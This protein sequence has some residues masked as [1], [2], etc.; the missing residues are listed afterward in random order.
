MT[1]IP[2]PEFFQGALLMLGGIVLGAWAFTYYHTWKRIKNKARPNLVQQ[3]YSF[4][5][6]YILEHRE[7]PKEYWVTCEHYNDLWR[8][9]ASLLVKPCKISPDGDFIFGM[10]ITISIGAW[11]DSVSRSWHDVHIEHFYGGNYPC[12]GP[13]WP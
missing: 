12:P 3:A 8:E 1:I 10:R 9:C 2:I 7:S 4:R 13:T 5:N 6:A 11:I